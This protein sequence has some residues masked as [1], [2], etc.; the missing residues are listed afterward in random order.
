MRDLVGFFDED[1]GRMLGDI[2]GAMAA[3]DAE[4]LHRAAHALK[5]M[6]GN[7]CSDR[8]YSAAADL[9]ARARAGD[10]AGVRERFPSL[11]TEAQALRAALLRFRA[12]LGV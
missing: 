12:S 2:E 8:A 1:I 7:Y 10:I 9:D 4:A 3:G 5:G 11:K 6:V